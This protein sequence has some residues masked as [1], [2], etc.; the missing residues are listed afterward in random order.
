M[1]AC[2]QKDPI[3]LFIFSD[4]SYY[5]YVQLVYECDI[6]VTVDLKSR[7]FMYCD[8]LL[9]QNTVTTLV[10]IYQDE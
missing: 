8:A 6:V 2:L 1:T 4:M 7:V 5:W 9:S 10:T 3:L